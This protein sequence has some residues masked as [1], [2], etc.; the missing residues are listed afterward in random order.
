VAEAPQREKQLKILL[1]EV[2]AKSHIAIEA[3]ELIPVL[4]IKVLMIGQ[5]ENFQVIAQ[6]NHLMLNAN[7]IQRIELRVQGKEIERAGLIKGGIRMQKADPVGNFQ[8]RKEN[9]Q[10]IVNVSPMIPS[11]S[12]IQNANHIQQ[13]EL[14]VQGKEIEKVDLIKEGIRMLK[15][16]PVGNL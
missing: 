8:D 1:I 16:D 7:H 9:F 4:Q 15:A 10:E 11:A 3:E 2:R 6:A 12:H 5:K 13:I 14:L